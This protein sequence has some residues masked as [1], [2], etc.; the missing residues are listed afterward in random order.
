MPSGID[1]VHA[2]NVLTS[3]ILYMEFNMPRDG[4]I[5]AFH[6]ISTNS[7]SIVIDGVTAE[8]I[9]SILRRLEDM[10][11]MDMWKLLTDDLYAHILRRDNPHEVHIDQLDVSI[12]GEL[13]RHWLN[14]GYDGSKEEFIEIFFQFID[15]I[16][17]DG[18]DVVMEGLAED[19]IPVV[20]VTA[21]YVDIHDKSPSAHEELFK[22]VFGSTENM[23]DLKFTPT[24]NLSRLCNLGLKEYYEYQ[25]NELGI[26]NYPLELIESREGIF[27]LQLRLND[28]V[29]IPK[30]PNYNFKLMRTD[31]ESTITWAHVEVR[32]NRTQLQ[33]CTFLD[34]GDESGSIETINIEHN[35]PG[36]ILNVV[37]RTNGDT[38][39]TIFTETDK[40]IVG[41]PT[42]EF[43]MPKNTLSIPNMLEFSEQIP[44]SEYLTLGCAYFH[45]KYDDKQ[46]R[47]LMT[48][49]WSNPEEELHYV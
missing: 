41:R 8:D 29:G 7:S 35:C 47:H 45:G 46:I 48:A 31:V 28:T 11:G 30:G 14:E 6:N 32:A 40:Y 20:A 36:Q 9:K 16:D 2:M 5:K 4:K 13:Y 33:V 24:F 38:T 12:I 42:F 1:I 22:S 23:V 43:V 39:V 25:T 3:V 21:K 44:D 26:M 19:K 10:Y 15:I 17:L 18:M 37:L 27:L 34:T 49:F